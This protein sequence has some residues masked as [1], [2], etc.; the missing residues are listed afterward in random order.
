MAG[1]FYIVLFAN[2][3]VV[4]FLSRVL[5][6]SFQDPAH[7]RPAPKR[8]KTGGSMC[9]ELFEEIDDISKSSRKNIKV[10]VDLNYDSGLD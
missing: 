10:W 1:K 6:K 5:I 4:D 8:S 3:N 9:R 7:E 2:Y